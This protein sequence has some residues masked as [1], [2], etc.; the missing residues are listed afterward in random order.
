MK[1]LGIFFTA[2]LVFTSQISGYTIN[3]VA[4][5]SDPACKN[6]NEVDIIIATEPGFIDKVAGIDSKYIKAAHTLGEYFQKI[7]F[8]LEDPTPGKAESALSSVKIDQLQ[9][10]AE[11]F[12][13]SF[14]MLSLMKIVGL[15]VLNPPKTIL[16]AHQRIKMGNNG[17]GS[18]WNA[19]ELSKKKNISVGAPLFISIFNRGNKQLLMLDQPIALDVNF[20]FRIAKDPFSEMCI[21]VPTKIRDNVLFL[22]K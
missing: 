16:V 15:N 2:L 20:G 7:G 11:Q 14:N 1:H 10:L 13:N 19:E 18:T 9:N 21:A 8:Y 12:K 4:K 6:I 22:K 5:D 3:F 17:D